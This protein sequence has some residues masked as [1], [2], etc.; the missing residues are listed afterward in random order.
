M[1]ADSQQALMKIHDKLG[2]CGNLQEI[3]GNV[4]R[5]QDANDASMC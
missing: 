3:D 1:G 4:S 2:E 5:V